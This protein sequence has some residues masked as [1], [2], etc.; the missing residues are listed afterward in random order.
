MQASPTVHAASTAGKRIGLGAKANALQQIA[1]GLSALIG[2]GLAY[3]HVPGDELNIINLIWLFTNFLALLDLGLGRSL[4]QSIAACVGSG[5]KDE[6]PTIFWTAISIILPLSL[7]AG[8]LLVGS[9]GLILHGLKGPF[10]ADAQPVLMLTGAIVPF[11]MVGIILVGVLQADSMFPQAAAVQIPVL[12]V[13][14]LGPGLLYVLGMQNLY[15]FA[16]LHL[17]TRAISAC[18]L[19]YIANRHYRLIGRFVFDKLR[20]ASL[21][22]FGGWVAVSSFIGPLLAQFDRLIVLRQLGDKGMNL[23][24]A[25]VDAGSRVM[26]VPISLAV[27]LFPVVSSLYAAGSTAEIKN[28][29]AKSLRMI[30]AFMVPMVMIGAGLSNEII[31]L[32]LGTKDEVAGMNFALILLG[33][34]CNG[35][36]WWVPYTIFQSIGK[37]KI[38]TFILLFELLVYFPLFGIAIHYFG[39]RGGTVVWCCRAIFEGVVV[40]ILARKYSISP[41]ADVR[42]SISPSLQI[43]MV[44]GLL[45]TFAAASFHLPSLARFGIV[46]LCLAIYLPSYIAILAKKDGFRIPGTKNVTESAPSP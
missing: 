4:N 21:L 39:L 10:P 44:C 14:Y 1:G 36:L 2:L 9:S 43:R 37:P 20:L 33:C 15:A 32:W 18:V 31:R 42:E 30:L 7:V 40:S 28:V 5:K 24:S 17:I 6:I 12:I 23:H 26:V 38:P 8:G 29:S 22:K 25:L 35:L 41:F 3:R 27:G 13:T 11:A 45:G 46:I 16:I 19:F 34:L